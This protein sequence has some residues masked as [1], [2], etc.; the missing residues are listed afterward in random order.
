LIVGCQEIS[1]KR[2]IFLIKKFCRKIA[3][4]PKY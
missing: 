3:A 2:L 1:H 4:E